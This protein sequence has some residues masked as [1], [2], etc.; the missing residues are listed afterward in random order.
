MGDEFEYLDPFD[1]VGNLPPTFYNEEGG[2]NSKKWQE[3]KDALEALLKLIS[4]NP[5]LD[6]KA[7][8]GELIST[9][10]RLLGKDANVNVNAVAAKCLAGVAYGL[11]TKF[12]PHASTVLPTVL[13][14]LKEKKPQLREPAVD[15]LDKV[16]F[17]TS[18]DSLQDALVGG[19]ENKNP[20]IKA[21]TAAFFY[22]AFKKYSDK[23]GKATLKAVAPILVKNTSDADVEVRSAS[24]EAL[25]SMLRAT[26]PGGNAL[27]K[28]IADDKARM[29]KVQAALEQAKAEVAEEQAQAPQAAAPSTVK[30]TQ[31]EEPTSTSVASARA[32]PTASAV[33]ADPFDFLDPFDVVSKLPATFYNEEGG[34]MSKKWQERKESLE[35]LLKLMTDNPKLDPKANYGELIGTLNKLLGKDANINVAALAAKCLG[36]VAFGLRKKFGPHASGLLPTI[37]EKFKEKKPLLRDPL[38]ECI[39]RVGATVDFEALEEG[40]VQGL[41]NKN[42]QIKAQT[43]CFVE[44][45]LRRST[46]QTMSKKIK[47]ICAHFVKHTGDPDVEV[48]EAAYNTLGAIQR[49]VGEKVVANWC[50]EVADDKMKMTKINEACQKLLGEIGPCVTAAP[51][52][53]ASAAPPQ[54]KPEEKK[55]AAPGKP[56]QPAQRPPSRPNSRRPSPEPEDES[57]PTTARKAPVAGKANDAQKEKDTGPVEILKGNGDKAQRL[58]DEAALRI[59]KWNFTTP[60]DEHIE[61]LSGLISQYAVSSLQ[62]MLFNKDFKMHIKACEEIMKLADGNPE[63]VVN[64]SDLLLK[65]CTLRFFETNPSA[66]IKVLELALRVLREC[67]RFEEP[68]SNTEVAAFLPYLLAKLGDPKD[69]I[70]G[71]IKDIV[72][73]MTSMCGPVK[74]TPSLLE[75]L[76]TKNARQ[77]SEILR[78]L[79]EYIDGGALTQMKPLGALKAIAPC[80]AD[81]DKNVREAAIVGMVS[82]YRCEGDSALK[83]AGK[84]AD[85]EMA[86][87]QERIKRMKIVPGQG[88]PSTPAGGA[89]IVKAEPVVRGR[90]PTRE[91]SPGPQSAKRSQSNSTILRQPLRKKQLQALSNHCSPERREILQK[92]LTIYSSEAHETPKA[93]QLVNEFNYDGMKTVARPRNPAAPTVN[94]KGARFGLDGDFLED[95]YRAVREERMHRIMSA[96]AAIAN[97]ENSLIQPTEMQFA[98]DMK[99]TTSQSSIASSVETLEQL[100]KTIN[101]VGSS[102]SNI[103]ND[104]IAQLIFVA[105]S[106]EQLPL[107]HER[108]DTLL[109][110]C[111]LQIESSMATAPYSSLDKASELIRNVF[112]LIQKIYISEECPADRHPLASLST[113][114][115]ES[116]LKQLIVT[117]SSPTLAA[118]DDF[119]TIGRTA[120]IIVI[121]LVNLCRPSVLFEALAHNMMNSGPSSNEWTMLLRIFNRLAQNCGNINFVART[122]L[123]QFFIA[124][125]EFCGYLEKQ[126]GGTNSAVVNETLDNLNSSIEKVVHAFRE[127]ALDILRR[128]PRPHAKIIEKVNTS[129]AQVKDTAKPEFPNNLPGQVDSPTGEFSLEK[130][131]SLLHSVSIDFTKMSRTIPPLAD[132]YKQYPSRVPI[133]EQKLIRYL[134]GTLISHNIRLYNEKGD[135]IVWPDE[136]ILEQLNKSRDVLL[137]TMGETVW[138]ERKNPLWRG[139]NSQANGHDLHMISS[140]MSDLPSVHAQNNENRIPSPIEPVRQPAKKP[141]RRSQLN[142]DELE[143]LRARLDAVT[144]N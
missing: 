97:L 110:M 44:R 66:L 136:T 30:N 39:D 71:V 25:G 53:S 106:P 23:T 85:K 49:I 32:A 90:A 61:Q 131:W 111:A 102:N 139:S 72:D 133:M 119:P 37:L 63:A 27:V 64:N 58:K 1:V 34:V 55:S 17:T 35:A 104:A 101:D 29:D 76:K 20:Q 87:I 130:F 141:P 68:F 125:S 82:A 21:Q 77:R 67:E 54:K 62:G 2:V 13:D 83:A 45:Y 46:P 100:D 24:I 127:Q 74:L 14:K 113:A 92:T 19:L 123:R 108:V 121:R 56:G 95:P 128:I 75:G 47:G 89:R 31:D 8:Y 9:L 114:V 93:K 88:L 117:V 73:S 143:N 79:S 116:L 41:E 16:A 28:E 7:N 15:C 52:P 137:S 11:R 115:C 124:A 98:R 43:D 78:I 94:Q 138:G 118:L 65:W 129:M 84:I 86:M 3:R 134:Y 122:D 105:Q 120:N 33:E 142:R 107:L 22:R 51:A 38:V 112:N 132:Y 18:L 80:V 5:K 103:A 126:A 81:A 70:R 42:P 36:G 4:D 40:L 60:T 109:Q 6:P 99:R 144:G 12:G 140:T 57:R 50:G 59:L 48:R 91:Q 69:H 96:T 10:N 26:G 135:R